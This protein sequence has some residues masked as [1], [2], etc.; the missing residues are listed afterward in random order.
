MLEQTSGYLAE[1]TRRYLVSRERLSRRGLGRSESGD[2]TTGRNERRIGSPGSRNINGDGV[3]VT[4]VGQGAEITGKLGLCRNRDD[5]GYE[6]LPE[7]VIAKE[8]EG[9]VAAIINFGYPHRSAKREAQVTLYVGI[10]LINLPNI[11]GIY[12]VEC[13]RS[14]KVFVVPIKE[15]GVAMNRV[16]SGLGAI[17][18]HALTQTILCR[19][20]AVRMSASLIES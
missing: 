11:V 13:A 10:G 9:F 12:I 15:K 16:G 1:A 6:G 5:G 14:S 8:P 20:R 17:L 7:P 3:A 4:G 19:E 18:L 2:G